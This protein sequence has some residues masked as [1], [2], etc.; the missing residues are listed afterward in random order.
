MID[1]ISLLNSYYKVVQ[2]RGILQDVNKEINRRDE[3]WGEQKH[4]LSDWMTILGRE[5]GQACKEVSETKMAKGLTEMAQAMD[6]LDGELVQVVAVC[7]C[8]L[9]KI[10]NKNVK[11]KE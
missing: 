9:E 5:F 10:R 11:N 4:D 3:K 7:F 8:I 2:Q 6:R 1:T